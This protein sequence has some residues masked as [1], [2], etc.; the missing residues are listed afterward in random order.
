MKADNWLVR[1]ATVAG[2]SKTLT[3][4]DRRTGNESGISGA[5]AELLEYY[6]SYEA[7]FSDFFNELY[8]M[9]SQKLSEL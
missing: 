8:E 1:Y 2:I 5:P 6:N 9:A 7:E 4:M 3:N